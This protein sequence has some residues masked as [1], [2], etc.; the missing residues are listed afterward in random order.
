MLWFQPSF[1]SSD[2]RDCRR[3]PFSTLRRLTANVTGVLSLLTQT[4]NN[5]QKLI[6][7][8]GLPRDLPV[9]EP[10]RPVY[11]ETWDALQAEPE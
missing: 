9:D 10:I 2:T 11:V 7:A 3:P 8:L 5:K 4:R 6:K 1:A